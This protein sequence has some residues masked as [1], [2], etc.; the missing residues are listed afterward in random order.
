[1][2]QMNFIVVRKSPGNPSE[3]IAR[4]VSGVR[5]RQLMKLSKESGASEELMLLER[6]STG[7]YAW[8]DRP[9]LSRRTKHDWLEF[10]DWQD[11]TLTARR[12][13]ASLTR[14]SSVSRW[15]L[16]ARRLDAILQ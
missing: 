10:F 12:H 8:A 2:A 6:Q 15:R 16:P 3:E 5:A 4:F 1:M 11:P 9:N 14:P 13:R 7:R